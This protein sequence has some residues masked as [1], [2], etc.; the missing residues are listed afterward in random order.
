MV[1]SEGWQV[2]EGGGG[3]CCG[4]GVSVWFGDG[5]AGGGEGGWRIGIWGKG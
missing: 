1:K 3:T 2:G 4:G 5:M